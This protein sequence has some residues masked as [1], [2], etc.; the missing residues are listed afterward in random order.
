MPS[1]ASVTS[2][3]SWEQPLLTHGW[4][5]SS[6][7][8]GRSHFQEASQIKHAETIISSLL[9]PSKN[10]LVSSMIN[11]TLSQTEI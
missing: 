5:N 3:P 2:L 10:I 11:K 9:L 8:D 6:K 4:E 1:A 7:D